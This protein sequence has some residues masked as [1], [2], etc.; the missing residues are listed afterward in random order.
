MTTLLSRAP[1]YGRVAPTL[2][3]ALAVGLLRIEVAEI[4]DVCLLLGASRAQCL[5]VWEGLVK[6]GWIVRRDGQWKPSEHI[7]ELAHARI[8]AAMPRAKA[9]GLLAAI[10]ENARRMNELAPTEEGVHWVTKL[11]V[12]GSYLSEKKQLGDLDI[13][14]ATAPREGSTIWVA[15][16]LVYGKD[17]M[18]KTR[19]MLRPRSP[20]L[21]LTN[22]AEML[23]LGC[24][25][26]LVYE[27]APPVA[28][29]ERH[30]GPRS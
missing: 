10:V 19:A 4:E 15:Q 30:T 6:D 14:W 27:F 11:A 22:Y 18:S 20:Y 28:R 5:P 2:V 7:R 25:Y 13:A 24:P 8:G 3:R 29:G 9:D 16:C 26:R 17:P 12:F 1:M 21:K 23:A